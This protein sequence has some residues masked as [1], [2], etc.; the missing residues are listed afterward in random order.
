MEKSTPTHQTVAHGPNHEHLGRKQKR[1][2]LNKVRDLTMNADDMMKEYNAVE[3]EEDGAQWPTIK[4][5]E[6]TGRKKFT[7]TSKKSH[8]NPPSLPSSIKVK[9][10]SN[11]HVSSSGSMTEISPENQVTM[12]RKC[13][14]KHVFFIW[15]FYQNHAHYSQD[16]R[17]RCGFLLKNNNL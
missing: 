2:L 3:E 15:K 6:S 1:Q 11:S 9:H 12:V 5:E 17:T 4:V 14:Q 13:V 16:E 8:Q 7:T 10:S